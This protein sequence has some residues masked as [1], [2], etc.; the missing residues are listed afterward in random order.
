MYLDTNILYLLHAVFKWLIYNAV[1]TMLYT[2]YPKVR[3]ITRI[4]FGR[5]HAFFFATLKAHLVHLV[6]QGNNFMA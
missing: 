4:H 1:Y 3:N 2:T 6:F 5:F